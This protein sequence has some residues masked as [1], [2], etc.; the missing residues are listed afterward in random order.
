MQSDRWWQAAKAFL[1]AHL[2]PEDSVVG[3]DGLGT[4]V[5]G[6]FLYEYKNLC[7]EPD[8]LIVH[9][10]RLDTLGP[11]YVRAALEVMHPSFLNEV[12]VVLTRRFIQPFER[13][14]H[15]RALT[16]ALHEAERRRE[17]P[18]PD[19]QPFSLLCDGRY[20]ELEQAIASLSA[21]D[22]HH[23]QLLEFFFQGRYWEDLYR[24]TAEC[25]HLRPASAAD[26]LFHAYACAAL[27][28]P[29]GHE[30][31]LRAL[32]ER[33]EAH[34]DS[35]TLR[36]V[37]FAALDAGTRALVE[38]IPPIREFQERHCL[39][40]STDRLSATLPVFDPSAPVDAVFTWVDRDDPAWQARFARHVGVSRNEELSGARRYTSIGE[41]YTAVASVAKQVAGLRHI[42][43]VTDGQEDRFDRSRLPP[44]VRARLRFTDHAEILSGTGIALPTFS[45]P[46]IE[47]QLHRIPGL[48]EVFLYLNDDCFLGQSF[49][50]GDLFQ[51]GLCQMLANRKVWKKEDLG[52]P[53]GHAAGQ[54]ATTAR[55]FL[56]RFGYLPDF[57][58]AHQLRISTRASF[59]ATNR[60]FAADFAARLF[61]SRVRSPDAPVFTLLDAW[62]SYHLGY[63][64]PQVLRPAEEINRIGIGPDLI[65]GA[66]A[67]PLKYYSINNLGPECRGMFDQFS[68]LLLRAQ[69]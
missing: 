2:Q 60:L 63:Q 46:V 45:S 18:A 35:L 27:D 44:A 34:Y 69:G 25:L 58:Q 10:G 1:D 11:G 13:S 24:L 41:I 21:A 51:G 59:A 49:G 28:R 23:P 29:F 15:F 36:I 12:F 40:F 42:H 33:H 38:G 14:A 9:K 16:A 3:P 37:D 31:A 55:L 32:L 67:R 47:S 68:D 39:R 19:T 66:E 52:A 43:I 65:R 5:P 8:V 53:P 26:L 57:V 56:D 54:H 20:R 4:G 30:A 7:P 62:V 61:P 22:R 48:S 64:E 6:Y 50:P 17:P